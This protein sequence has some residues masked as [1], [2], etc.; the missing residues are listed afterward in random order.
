M[1]GQAHGSKTVVLG[2]DEIT[3]MDPVDQGKV[4]T[5]GS[6]IENQSFGTIPVEF[7]GGIAQQQAGN[8]ELTAKTDGNIHH[9]A[10]VCIDQDSHNVTS[11]GDYIKIE[12]GRQ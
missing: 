6:L 8:L 10:A 4:Y 11:W 7:V 1:T 12:E 9:G 3:L 2:D 5:V